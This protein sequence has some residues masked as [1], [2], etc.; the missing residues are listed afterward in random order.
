MDSTVKALVLYSATP[1][2][3]NDSPNTLNLGPSPR[4]QAHDMGPAITAKDNEE[5]PFPIP[6]TDVDRWVLSQTDEEFHYHDWDELRRIIGM[7]RSVST[8][9]FVPLDLMP[10]SGT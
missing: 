2:N 5:P 7:T 6:L 3:E 9:S 1:K 4:L 10:A 8:N